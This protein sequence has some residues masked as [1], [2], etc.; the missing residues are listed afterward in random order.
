VTAG[1]A[2]LEGGAASLFLG[3]LWL[4]QIET[5]QMDRPDYTTFLA[6]ELT[7]TVNRHKYQLQSYVS[8]A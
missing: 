2:A 3:G 4:C 8:K 7:D 5:K 6:K 1:S